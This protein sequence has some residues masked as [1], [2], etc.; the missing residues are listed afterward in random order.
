MRYEPTLSPSVREKESV[1]PNAA[2]VSPFT[3]PASVAIKVGSAVPKVLV[4]ASA[5]TDKTAL[6]I[7]SVTVETESVVAADQAARG[8]KIAANI[9]TGNAT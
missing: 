7:V 6:V 8:D 9:L 3:N 1:P 5:V 2:A 4:S